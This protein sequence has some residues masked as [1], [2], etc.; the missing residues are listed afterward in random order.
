L[1]RRFLTRVTDRRLTVSLFLAFLVLFCLGLVLP[2]RPL[3][4]PGEAEAFAERWPF[5]DRAMRATGLDDV[6]RSGAMRLVFWACVLQ[7]LAWLGLRTGPVLREALRPRAEPPERMP[8][9]LRS[10]GGRAHL[11]ALI[12]VLRSRRFHLRETTEASWFAVKNRFSGISSLVFHASLVLV[13]GGAWLLQASTFRGTTVLA[14]GQPFAGTRGEYQSVTPAGVRED[15][16]PKVAFTPLSLEPVFSAAGQAVDVACEILAGDAPGE[17]KRVAV[18]RPARIGDVEVL[19]HGFDL[20][21]VFTVRQG[22]S[23][24]QLDAQC[25][26]LGVWSHGSP[27]DT[28]RLQHPPASVHARFFPDHEQG[29][30][31]HRTRGMEMRNPA[32][33]LRVVMDGEELPAAEG[34]LK[35]GESLEFEGARMTL[36]ELRT[37]GTYH[38]SRQK[39]WLLILGFLVMVISITLRFFFARQAVAVQ[40]VESDRGPVVLVGGRAAFFPEGLR[41]ELETLVAGLKERAQRRSTEEEESHGSR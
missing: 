2:Q 37:W 13:L 19:I 18:N 5:V 34:L 17:P 12:Q 31:G 11:E 33:Y 29:P 35:P 32:L 25:V 30:E 41:H 3:L 14:E 40:L 1:L 21:P 16:L 38:L 9:Q 27:E 28:F 10:A 24:R 36:E 8:I 6:F 23:G 22:R 26:R 39:G 15:A 7:L 20:A 4:S